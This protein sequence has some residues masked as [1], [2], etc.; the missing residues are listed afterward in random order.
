MNSI[1]KIIPFEKKTVMNFLNRWQL[2]HMITK[3][4]LFESISDGIVLY[5]STNHTWKKPEINGFWFHAGTLKAALDRMKSFRLQ[6]NPHIIQLKMSIKKPLYIGRDYRFHN[7]L[8]KVSKELYKDGIIN[9]SELDNFSQI[10]SNY[11]TF[12]NLRKLLHDKYG[13]DGVIY[14]N[15]I[16]DRGSESYIAFY[17]EQIEIL[18]YDYK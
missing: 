12:D 6:I 8:S 3:L 15:N 16:E 1:I 4:K 11:A 7:D 2:E 18:D 9:K 10:Y 5:H 14:R 17:P 13:Y